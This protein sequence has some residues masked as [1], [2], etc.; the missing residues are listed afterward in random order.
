MGSNR[1]RDKNIGSKVC[2][3]LTIYIYKALRE[4]VILSSFQT[5]VRGGGQTFLTHRGGQTF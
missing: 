5:Q 4:S 2:L 1:L 3:G